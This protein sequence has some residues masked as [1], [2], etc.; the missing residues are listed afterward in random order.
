[1]KTGLIAIT[2]PDVTG[3][4]RMCEALNKSIEG[5]L[6]K[7]SNV[8]V[9]EKDQ[10]GN[11]KV[12]KTTELAKGAPTC[13]ELSFVVGLLLRGSVAKDLLGEAAG[14]LLIH[15][16]DLG[17]PTRKTNQLTADM[18]AKSSVLFIQN[19]SN[20]NGTFEAVFSQSEGKLHDLPM[21]DPAIQ[22]VKI[23]SST[24]DYYWR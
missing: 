10:Q 16:I 4:S 19:C 13:C 20:L 17:I 18:A 7:S 14:T 2:F 24:L 8:L 5:D 21:N 1:M 6:S 11:L 15:N 3:A 22:E 23:M 9:V 12:N